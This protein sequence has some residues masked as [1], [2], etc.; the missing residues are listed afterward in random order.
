MMRRFVAA[1]VATA[2]VL[3]AG[4][5]ASTGHSTAHAAASPSPLPPDPPT[6]P[7]LLKIA[8]TFNDH[9][10]NGGYGP[11]ARGDPSGRTPG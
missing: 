2:A 9:Y 5:T 11:V 10:D 7:A 3:A 1:A 6:A 8:T 4:C